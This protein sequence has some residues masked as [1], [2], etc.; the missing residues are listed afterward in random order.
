MKKKTLLLLYFVFSILWISGT[1]QLLQHFTPSPMIELIGRLKELFYVA[2]TG[3]FIYITLKR[4]EERNAAKTEEERLSTLINSMVDFVNFKDGE[5]RWIQAN[6]F[7]LKLFQIE[8]VDYK[9]K[10][11]SELAEYSTYYAE[12]LRYCETSDEEAWHNGTITR[13][14]ETIPLPDG[15]MKTFDAIKVPLF[16][17]DGSRQ[18]LVIMGRDITERKH[19]EKLLAESQQQYKSLFD[20]SPDIV[21]LIDLEGN[22]TNLNP[23]FKTITGYNADDYIGKN[24]IDVL[25][26]RYKE[27]ICN[28]FKTVITEI[29]PQMSELKIKNNNGDD[30]ILECTSLP[31][32]VNGERAGI[33]G[34][35]KD[36][37][38]LRKAEERL[39]MTEKLSVVGELSASVAHEIRNPL[40]SLIG[41]VQLM[42]ME[43]DKHEFYYKIMLDELNRINHIVGELLLLA[44]PQQINFTIADIQA[45]LYDVVS[46][47]KTEANLHNI[48]ID[49]LF[50]EKTAL[51][52]CEPNQL[53]QLFINIIKNAV[54]A[55]DSGES[56]SISLDYKD[57]E[58][59]SILIK[60]NG[61]GMSKDRLEKIGEPFY[62]SKEKGTGLGLTVS[63]KIVQQHNGCMTFKSEINEGT[64][65]MIELPVKNSPGLVTEKETSVH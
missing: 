30:I 15:G 7:G 41:F 22:I 16:N 60:D 49:L 46:L 42:R 27:S 13:V 18:G 32:I 55:S 8:H 58:K 33:I 24:V 25:P 1:N 14:E 62:S 63:S 3:C 4:T 65:V 23:Q 26:Q 36:I 40:T 20:H 12:A 54:E 39:R 31:I 51:I 21:Y 47:L 9:G 52:E 48:Q 50:Q 6:E 11:D 45:I 44:K 61:S 53:K 57:N 59:A 56:V 37:T 28:F 19:V 43:D 29:K 5:G 64:E 2:V 34:Y 10:K 38:Q 17:P 35:G